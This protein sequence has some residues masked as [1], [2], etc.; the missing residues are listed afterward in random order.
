MADDLRERVAEVLAMHTVACRYDD[1]G[2]CIGWVCAC[3]EGG[4]ADRDV[5]SRYAHH[6]EDDH[7]ADAVLAA[8]DLDAR[9]AAAVERGRR[10]AAEAVAFA[11]RDTATGRDGEAKQTYLVCAERASRFNSE[12]IDWWLARKAAQDEHGKGTG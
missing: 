12:R 3:G 1:D 8:L 10:E 6:A 11:L 9:V 4:P 2:E 5:P 7:H